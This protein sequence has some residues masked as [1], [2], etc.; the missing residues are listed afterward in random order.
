MITIIVISNNCKISTSWIKISITI[1]KMI[2]KIDEI[3]INAL[4]LDNMIVAGNNNE[5]WN[6]N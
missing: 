1:I 6:K 3:R 2:R 5:I 4:I